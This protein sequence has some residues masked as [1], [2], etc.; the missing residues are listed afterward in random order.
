M[1]VATDIDAPTRGAPHESIF[2]AA[3][4]AGAVFFRNYQRTNYRPRFGIAQRADSW[5][6]QAHA[7]PAR[8]AEGEFSL[9]VQFSSRQWGGA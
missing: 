8:V 6:L 7:L 4:R 2:D 5:T 1:T 3:S 9:A